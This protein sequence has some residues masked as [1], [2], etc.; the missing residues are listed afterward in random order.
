MKKINNQGISALNYNEISRY[1]DKYLTEEE[2]DDIKDIFDNLFPIG[3]FES[4]SARQTAFFNFSAGAI[5]MHMLFNRGYPR[6]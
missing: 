1:Y 6:E 4:D 5:I 3:G 2:K